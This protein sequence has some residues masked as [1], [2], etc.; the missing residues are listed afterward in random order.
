MHHPNFTANR[1]VSTSQPWQQVKYVVFLFLVVIVWNITSLVA[2][3]QVST[4]MIM[5]PLVRYERVQFNT[6]GHRPSFMVFPVW[7]DTDSL[8]GVWRKN[9]G[10][11]RRLKRTSTVQLPPRSI[12]LSLFTPEY[13]LT[14]NSTFPFG[15]NDGGLWQGRGINQFYSTGLGLTYGALRFSLRPQVT[16]VENRYYI[17]S[18]H[19]PPPD[20]NRRGAQVYYLDVPTR[21]GRKTDEVRPE[22]DTY[23]TWYP[24]ES[25]IQ[26]EMNGIA[27]GL[28]TQQRW[29]GPAVLNPILLSTN[30]PGFLHGFVSSIRPVT[31][32]GGKTEFL[33][34]WGGLRESRFFDKDP[35]NN[36]RYTSGLNLTYSPTRLKGLHLGMARVGYKYYPKNGL[37]IQDLFL[38]LRPRDQD[39]G[40]RDLDDAYD[41]YVM[42]NTYFFRHVLDESAFEWYMEYGLNSFRRPL[43]D[44]LAQSNLNRAYTIGA[45][46]R[47]DLPSNGHFLTL[48]IEHTQ[49]ENN[50]AG[51]FW[52]ERIG[53]PGVTIWYVSD[54]I[55]Q[56]YTHQG[57]I[58]GAGIGPGSNSQ[59]VSFTWYHTLGNVELTLARVAYNNDRLFKYADYYLEQDQFRNTIWRYQEMGRSLGLSTTFF[60]SSNVDFQAAYRTERRFRFE[61]VKNQDLSNTNLSFTLRYAIRQIRLN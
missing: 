15:H 16:H 50:S 10:I 13:R 37:P 23:T 53:E 39:P 58:L 61:N 59:T 8:N 12:E 9:G 32:Y 60:L 45:I 22:M 55:K 46:K 3:A 4:P 26:L 43:G 18:Y 28:S 6:Q 17:L 11:D 25:F 24:G 49:L 2:L 20:I 14:N 19:R 52:R 56:G 57:K 27:A 1:L 44:R 48:L 38:A 31:V 42:M 33:W 35:G 40:S 36:L 47:F 7:M 5:D 54:E 30:A 34:F 41:P 29:I 21:P 51:A